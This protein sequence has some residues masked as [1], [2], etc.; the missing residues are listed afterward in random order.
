LIWFAV[1]RTVLFFFVIPSLPSRDAP[2]GS[3]APRHSEEILFD[4]ADA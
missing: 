1:W 2:D 4:Q 3:V